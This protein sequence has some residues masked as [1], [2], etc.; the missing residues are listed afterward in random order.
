MAADEHP[1]SFGHHDVHFQSDHAVVAP[2]VSAQL[3][4][5][6]DAHFWGI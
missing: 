6:G 2:A 5:L 3:G 4:V 1:G